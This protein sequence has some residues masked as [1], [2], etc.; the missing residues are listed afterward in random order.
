MT[1]APPA[2]DVPDLAR[3]F[4][5]VAKRRSVEHRLP[6]RRETAMLTFADG[7]RREGTLF[8]QVDEKTADLFEDGLAF[9]PVGSGGKV[10][11]YARAT[12]ACATLPS[13]HVE[14][15]EV[16]LIVRKVTVHM[17]SGH[18]IEGEVRYA[19]NVERAR[20]V[21]YLNSAPRGFAVHQADAV[22]YVAKA[23]VDYVEES[24]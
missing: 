17:R 11:L 14:T 16:H 10:R 21:D 22:H 18:T 7:S 19:P 24:E 23:H 5:D 13:G 1:S 8:F 9:L 15:D 6:V 3:E 4:L 20:A 2:E 12:I